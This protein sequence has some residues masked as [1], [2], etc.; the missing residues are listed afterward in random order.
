M[1]ATSQWTENKLF[2]VF[3]MLLQINMSWGNHKR[4]NAEYVGVCACVY[5][6]CTLKHASLFP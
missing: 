2:A 6:I 4:K 5:P 3:H 1:R